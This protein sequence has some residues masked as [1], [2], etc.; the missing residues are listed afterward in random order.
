MEMEHINEDTIR[1]SIKNEDLAARGITFLDLLG[2]RKEIENFFYSILEEVDVEEEFKGSDAVTFQVMP[3]GDGLEL[4]ISKNVSFDN[5]D[6]Y[7]TYGSYYSP[8]E[9]T[10]WLKHEDPENFEGYSQD[11]MMKWFKERAAEKSAD[12]KQT[13]DT[14]ARRSF[15]FAFD[16]FE[17]FIQS[18]KEVQLTEARTSLYTLDQLYYLKVDFKEDITDLSI[19]DQLAHLFEFAKKKDLTPEYLAEHGQVIMADRALE[20]TRKYFK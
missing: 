3:K 6:P 19:D 5:I 2:N 20:Q 14:V 17:E 9:I 12:S 16:S 8:E 10:D 15:V 7:E 13:T 4:F 1:V 18:A 11:E